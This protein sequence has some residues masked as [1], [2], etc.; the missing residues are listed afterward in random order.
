MTEGRGEGKYG[1]IHGDDEAQLEFVVA[2]ST[3]PP[4]VLLDFRRL[5]G[6]LHLTP[7]EAREMADGLNSAANEA[8]GGSVILSVR[9]VTG[10]D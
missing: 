3:E 1:S 2:S 5:V 9:R 7:R 6:H 8:D 4:L 10:G